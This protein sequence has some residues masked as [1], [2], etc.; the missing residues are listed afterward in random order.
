MAN[1]KPQSTKLSVCD[2]GI[3]I[4]VS[5]KVIILQHKVKEYINWLNIVNTSSTLSDP[6]MPVVQQ[7]KDVHKHTEPRFQ[8]RI[9][10]W[11]IKK[12]KFRPPDSGL[13][14][15]LPVLK[16]QEMFQLSEPQALKSE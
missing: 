5:L 2:L 3:T 12:T 4:N 8:T 13:P 15:P 1:E 6:R 14:L 10:S 7:N 16:M 9:L 11:S